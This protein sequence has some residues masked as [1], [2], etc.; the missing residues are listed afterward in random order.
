MGMASVVVLM[1]DSLH[2]LEK[3]PDAG[4]EIARAVRMI[5]SG[6]CGRDMSE[7]RYGKAISCG[8]VSGRQVVVTD[9]Y[10]GDELYDLNP[11]PPEVASRLIFAL[12]RNGYR[13]TKRKKPVSL[14]LHVE[15]TGEE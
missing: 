10:G 1:N 9:G 13:V 6:R 12:E 3:D 4:A 11:L 2:D 14:P 8:H 5:G 7:F 15:R